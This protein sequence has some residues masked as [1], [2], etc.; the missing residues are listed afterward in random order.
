MPLL[1][2]ILHESTRA[3]RVKSLQC[4]QGVAVARTF[5]EKLFSAMV[6]GLR[7]GREQQRGPG[8][9]MKRAPGKKAKN[10]LIAFEG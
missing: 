8:E 10:A 7:A 3:R 9:G 2:S 4:W 1:S 6:F 5:S